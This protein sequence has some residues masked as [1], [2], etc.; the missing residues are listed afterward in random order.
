M[1]NTLLAAAGLAAFKTALAYDATVC[2][3]DKFTSEDTNYICK[4]TTRFPPF[5]S[6][7]VKHIVRFTPHPPSALPMRPR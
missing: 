4:K 6:P 5:C 7:V 1:R 2:G 3:K